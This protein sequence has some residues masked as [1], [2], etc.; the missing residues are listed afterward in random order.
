MWYHGMSK[1]PKTTPHLQESFVL[2]QTYMA[3]MDNEEAFIPK[4]NT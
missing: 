4:K 2:Y 3:L 1:P